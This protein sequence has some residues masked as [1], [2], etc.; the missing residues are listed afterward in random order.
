MLNIPFYANT[1]PDPN[2]CFQVSMK[3]VLDYFLNKEFDVAYLDQITNRKKGKWTTPSQIVPALYDLGLNLRYYSKID[4]KPFLEG[5]SFIRKQYG[6]AAD[7]MLGFID[8]DVT[9]SSIKNLLKYDL[10]AIKKLGIPEIEANV[11]NKFVQM[12]IIDW[13][14][15]TEVDKPYQGHMVIITGFDDENIYL[16]NPGPLKAQANMKVTKEK[17]MEAFN[18]NGTDNDIVVIYG[19]R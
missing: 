9:I 6:E 10:F 8:V 18:A 11:K 16:H 2:Q 17:F 4:I 12:A 1:G 5:E 15:I 3:S 14:K 13:F 7:K 19:R